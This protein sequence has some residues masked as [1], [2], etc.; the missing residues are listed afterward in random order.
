MVVFGSGGHT[1]E[2]IKMIQALSS[3]LFGPFFF[4]L[5]ASDSTSMGSIEAA[6]LSYAN[7]VSVHKIFR[8][9]EVHQSWLLT[10]FTTAWSLCQSCFLVATL[11]PDVLLANGPGK[12]NI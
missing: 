8:S 3:E 11:R 5:A 2:M 6:K 9:R 7:S 4:V 1:A 10:V 12:V